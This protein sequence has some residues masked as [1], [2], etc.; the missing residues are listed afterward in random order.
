MGDR[1]VTEYGV[2]IVGD[3]DLAGHDFMFFKTDRGPLLFLTRTACQSEM[4]LADAWATWRTMVTM[5]RLIPMGERH[6]RAVS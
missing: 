2:K 5:P 1:R 3:D 6:L 4:C